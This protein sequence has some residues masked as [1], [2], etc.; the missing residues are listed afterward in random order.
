[1][2]INKNDEQLT[3]YDATEEELEESGDEED[4]FITMRKMHLVNE[5]LGIGLQ[6]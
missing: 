3:L 2:A 6:V 1:M 5:N 4:R